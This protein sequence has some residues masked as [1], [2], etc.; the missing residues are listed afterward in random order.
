MI[1]IA[2]DL[3]FLALVGASLGAPAFLPL[4]EPRPACRRR[5]TLAND[6]TGVNRK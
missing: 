2:I 1:V 4:F 3:L 6:D 5:A